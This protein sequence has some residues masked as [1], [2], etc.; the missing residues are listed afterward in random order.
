MRLSPQVLGLL[1]STAIGASLGGCGGASVATRPPV[2]VAARVATPPVVVAA[3]VVPPVTT[4]A[5]PTTPLPAT[6]IATTPDPYDYPVD[7][8]RG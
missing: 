4:N 5:T 8:G 2:V 6:Q 7:C 1:A 3:R